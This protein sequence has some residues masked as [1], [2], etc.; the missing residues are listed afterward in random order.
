ME[1]SSPGPGVCVREGGHYWDQ[2]GGSV[3]AD[4]P[5]EQQWL[6]AEFVLAMGSVS[7]GVGGSLG[8]VGAAEAAS[9]ALGPLLGAFDL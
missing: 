2:T 9:P 4:R 6:K 1:G 3:C 5:E 8:I 7:E